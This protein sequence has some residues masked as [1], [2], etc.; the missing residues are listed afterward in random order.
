M[1]TVAALPGNGLGGEVGV[2]AV[3]DGHR[4]D[5]GGKEQGVVRRRHGIGIAEVDFILAGALLVVGAFRDNAHALQG[6]ADLPADI[7]PLVLRGHVH[8]ARM[9]KGLSG[10]VAVGIGFKEVKF[11]F[12][13]DLYGKTQLPGFPDGLAQQ[14]PAVQGEGAAVGVADLAEHPHHLPPAGPPGQHRQGGG[15]GKQEQIRFRRVAE[16]CHGRGIK[17]NALRKRTLQLLGHDGNILLPSGYVAED[18]ADEL[19]ILGL[20]IGEHIF[21]G[22][23]HSRVLSCGVWHTKLPFL[24]RQFAKTEKRTLTGQR[25]FALTQQTS[26]FTGRDYTRNKPGCQWVFCYFSSVFG[27]RPG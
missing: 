1:H 24:L 9:V 3:A 8:I 22:I 14:G 17:G 18:Q 15:D 27:Q 2:Q 26:L 16:A 11:K 7:L 20:H 12:R 21:F 6:Q 5:G 13:P 23:Q 25:H 10:G 4:P 19:Y